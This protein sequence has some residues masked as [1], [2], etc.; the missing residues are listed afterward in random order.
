[1]NEVCIQWKPAGLRQ[2]TVEDKTIFLLGSE[3]SFILLSQTIQQWC[4]TFWSSTKWSFYSWVVLFSV[5]P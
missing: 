5:W 4:V 1:M 2:S 3:I